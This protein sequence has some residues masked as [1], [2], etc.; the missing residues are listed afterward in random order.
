MTHVLPKGQ[1]AE[2]SAVELQDGYFLI[3]ESDTHGVEIDSVEFDQHPGFVSVETH[4][5]WMHLDQN[6]DHK[7]RVLVPTALQ[8]SV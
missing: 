6:P 5:G 7:Y 3:G 4:V 8:R 2:K 1:I